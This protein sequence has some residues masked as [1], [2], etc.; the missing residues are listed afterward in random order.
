MEKAFTR[1]EEMAGTI[2]EYINTRI[3]SVKLSTAEKASKIAANLLAGIFAV[4]VFIFFMIFTG[5]ALALI[6][7]N[8]IGQTWAGFGLIALLY[9]VIGMVAWIARGKLIRLPLMNALIQQLF[10][11]DEED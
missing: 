1:A 7:G 9:L 2:R 5:I 8:W 4:I 10:N 3:E 6:L 11:D